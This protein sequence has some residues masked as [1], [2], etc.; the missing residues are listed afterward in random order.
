MRSTEY[1]GNSAAIKG[2]CPWLASEDILDKGDVT[3]TIEACHAVQEAEFEGGRKEDVYTLS[4]VG[5]KKQLVLNSTNRK[6]LVKLYGTNVSDWK[7]KPVT[8]WVDRNVRAFGEIRNGIRIRPTV[9]KQQPKKVEQPK[10]DAFS[11][12]GLVASLDEA[13]TLIEVEV[14]DSRIAAAELSAVQIKQLAEKIEV[15]RIALADN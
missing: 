11:F 10:P 6:T 8:L 5:A 13:T 4:F 9:P 15:A 1:T 7:G 14:I 3:V 12:E 2:D